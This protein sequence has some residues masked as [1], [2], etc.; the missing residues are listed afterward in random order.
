VAATSS[1]TTAPTSNAINLTDTT[2]ALQT[3]GAVGIQ[4]YM[5]GNSSA[6]AI[7]ATYSQISVTGPT[8]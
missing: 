3:G 6:G 7:K 1:G 2:P 4:S 5:A 8:S